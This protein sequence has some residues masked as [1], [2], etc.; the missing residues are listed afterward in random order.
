MFKS[1]QIDQQCIVN[2]P[3]QSPPMT[4]PLDTVDDTLKFLQI[5][6]GLALGAILK[7]QWP[8]ELHGS[9]K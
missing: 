5:S 7:K 2:P 1:K 8:K 6:I 9:I 3:P 4:H